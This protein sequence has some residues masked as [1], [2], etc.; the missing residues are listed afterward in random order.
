[1]LNVYTL[2]ETSPGMT[3]QS[4]ERRRNEVKPWTPSFDTH[5]TTVKMCS[6]V[7]IVVCFFPGGTSSSRNGSS[8]SRVGASSSKSESSSSKTQNKPAAS[9]KVGFC[10]W[11]SYFTGRCRC[12]NV[13]TLFVNVWMQCKVVCVKFDVDD[14]N[15]AYLKK[16]LGQFGAIVK[17]I[18]FPKLVWHFF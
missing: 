16:L 14:V 11:C 3:V 6:F 5:L 9:T 8:G 18:M 7:L 12:Y 10:F 13:L 1:M 17:I 4:P 2:T 15:E